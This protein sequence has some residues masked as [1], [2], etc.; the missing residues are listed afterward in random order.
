MLLTGALLVVNTNT[1][2][3]LLTQT[4]GHNAKQSVGTLTFELERQLAVEVD[5]VGLLLRHLY[6]YNSVC[7]LKQATPLRLPGRMDIGRISCCFEN[8]RHLTQT[9]GRSLDETEAPPI[10]VWLRGLIAQSKHFT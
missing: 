1:T 4:L 9:K 2:T 3:L 7:F 5:E 8:T 10:K 6:G